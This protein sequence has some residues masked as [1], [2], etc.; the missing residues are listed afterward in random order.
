MQGLNNKLDLNFGLDTAEGANPAVCQKI[1][2]LY[3]VNN[4]KVVDLLLYVLQTAHT[5]R[6]LYI[7]LNHHN[8]LLSM[9][10]LA[11]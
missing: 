11:T 7:S 8:N 6:Y 2:I 9:T 4:S 1:I 5:H 10:V 3:L